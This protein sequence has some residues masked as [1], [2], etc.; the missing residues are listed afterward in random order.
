MNRSRLEPFV[1]RGLARLEGN[2]LI[3]LPGNEPYAR[4]IASV[5]DAYRTGER[6]FS[7]AV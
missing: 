4:S 3:L 5:F 1:A 2:V 7:S 6:Q